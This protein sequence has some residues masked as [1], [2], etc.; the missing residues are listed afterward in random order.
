MDVEQYS[1]KMSTITTFKRLNFLLIY[2]YQY[3]TFA[4][5]GLSS[6]SKRDSKAKKSLFS[7]AKRKVSSSWTFDQFI[8]V[9]CP[10]M[11]NLIFRFQNLTRV[12]CVIFMKLAQVSIVQTWDKNCLIKVRVNCASSYIEYV[13]FVLSIP[14]I[15][16]DPNEIRK[17]FCVLKFSMH[18]D[19]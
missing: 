14:A 17:F 11:F 13:V 16:D 9:N 4:E 3:R 1:K 19:I 6:I 8:K 2:I 15:V 10:A 12:L 18:E 5:W 7:S